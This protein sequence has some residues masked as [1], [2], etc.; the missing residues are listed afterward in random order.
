MINTRIAL[1]LMSIVA[2]LAVVGASTFAL[3]TD[4]ATAVGNTFSTGN[5]G[6]LISKTGEEETFTESIP[7]PAV[8]ESGIF[9]GFSESYAFTLRNDSP[10]GVDL[11]LTADLANLGGLFHGTDGSLPDKVLVKWT[12]GDVVS[13]EYSVR[14]WIEGGNAELGVL[15]SGE[16]LACTMDVRIPE[17]AGN[18]IAG[19]D[20]TFDG[21]YNGTQVVSVE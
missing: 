14:Q 20:I 5:A 18:E 8:L 16:D 7:S 19:S 10:E 6:L 17:S 3:F 15:P 13:G 9:P 4:T 11:N 2:A 21:V 1:S 12:C